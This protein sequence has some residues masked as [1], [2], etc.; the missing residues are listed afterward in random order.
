MDTDTKEIF[1]MMNSGLLENSRCIM[2]NGKRIEKLS[3]KIDGIMPYVA[4]KDD[5]TV[6]IAKQARHCQHSIIPPTSYQQ[7]VKMAAKATL[8]LSAVAG[9]VVGIIKAIQS[10]F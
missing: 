10:F 5:L 1:R 3:G 2:E 6:A 7:M 4:T 8:V 9:A